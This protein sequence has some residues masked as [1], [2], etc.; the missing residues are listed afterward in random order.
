MTKW[1]P[2]TMT[3][4]VVDVPAVTALG[5]RPVMTGTGSCMWNATGA[6]VPPPGATV[7]TVI[8]R[9]PAFAWSATVSCMVS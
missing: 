7:D 6:E 2:V 8:A 1:L 9:S 5:E 3:A 4:V